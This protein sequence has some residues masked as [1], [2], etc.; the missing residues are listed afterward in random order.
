MYSLMVAAGIIAAAAVT[1]GPNNLLVMRA[2]AAGGMSQAL[3]AIGAIVLGSIGLLALVV[4][5][6]GAL[7]ERHPVLRTLVTVAG[8][9][10]LG[11]LGLRLALSASRVPMTAAGNRAGLPDGPARVFVF[12]FLNPKGWVLVLTAVAAVQADM[13]AMAAFGALAMLFVAIL[14][15]SLLLWSLFGALFV[16]AFTRP[17]FSLWFDRTLGGLLA[18]C[19][20][21]LF[22]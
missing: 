3:P 11:C 8:A 18:V 14:S 20:L 15:L 5:G 4:A 1:P 13:S 9:L 10:Y 22:L 19:S 7:F 16:T 2:A 21:L 6:G 17:G 12:Q